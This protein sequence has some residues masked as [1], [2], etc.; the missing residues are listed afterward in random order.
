VFI[1]LGNSN[2]IGPLVVS[3]F[4]VDISAFVFGKILQ[5]PKLIPVISPN[6]T[7]SG[8]ICATLIGASCFKYLLGNLIFEDY[9]W[10]RVFFYGMLFAISAQ[11]GDLIVSL[12][13]R[14]CNKKDFT[15]WLPGHGGLIDR[16]D[17]IVAALIFVCLLNIFCFGELF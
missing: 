7:W 1:L 14:V 10:L 8:A 4:A 2:L 5:G 11:I 16:A 3:V 15:N 6:K 17:S 9:S 13:K 12:A